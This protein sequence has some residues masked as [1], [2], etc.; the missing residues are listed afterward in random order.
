MLKEVTAVR[1][2][3]PLVRKRWFESD[4]FDLY[5]WEEGGAI[6]HMQLCYDRHRPGESAISWKQGYGLFHDGVDAVRRSESPL[7]EAGGAFDAERVNA[8]FLRESAGLPVDVRRFV[9]AKLHEFALN[10]PVK[11][12]APRRNRVRR[13]SW[14][15]QGEGGS[16]R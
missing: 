14:Q 11:R 16:A 10:G 4:F 7:L 8:R 9:L 13:E 15:A 1:Q 5:L 3:D 12:G 2:G 6:V